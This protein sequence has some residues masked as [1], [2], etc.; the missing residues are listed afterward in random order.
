MERATEGAAGELPNQGT[1]YLEAKRGNGLR[2]MPFGAHAPSRG[3]GTRA[4][5][6]PCV[7]PVDRRGQRGKN[8][9]VRSPGTRKRQCRAWRDDGIL[10]SRDPHN[11]PARV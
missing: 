8:G 9:F 11:V 2:I 10:A 5:S 4:E 1:C 3:A 7:A 6:A